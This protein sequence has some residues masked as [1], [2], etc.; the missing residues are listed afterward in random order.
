[1]IQEYPL[2]PTLANHILSS[3]IQEKAKLFMPETC[4]IGSCWEPS[5]T[6]LISKEKKMDLKRKIMSQHSEKNGEQIDNK[7]W[8]LSSSNF[9]RPNISAVYR[10]MQ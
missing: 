4:K 9:L 6:M 2:D 10:S 5:S 3:E 8:C 7:L 1:M